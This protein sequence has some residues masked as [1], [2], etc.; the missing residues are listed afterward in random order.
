MKTWSIEKLFLSGSLKNESQSR[1]IRI[2][3][4]E[5]KQWE[6]VS[7]LYNLT[8]NCFQFPII[9][10]PRHYKF[11]PHTQFPKYTV[12]VPN[13]VL[14]CTLMCLEF[15]PSNSSKYH[16]FCESTPQC[17]YL[18]MSYIANN[19]IRVVISLYGKCFCLHS[20]I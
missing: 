15:Q 3:G 20:H 9:P 5:Q 6:N 17:L 7:H 16:F 18:T 10:T 12:L 8:L 19:C 14:S 1:I 13:P 2:K 11:E 4:E